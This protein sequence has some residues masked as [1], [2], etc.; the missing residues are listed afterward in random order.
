M[1]DSVRKTCIPMKNSGS[2]LQDMAQETMGS[3]RIYFLAAL[4]PA[5]VP[6]PTSPARSAGRRSGVMERCADFQA[7][8][9]PQRW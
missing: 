6:C 7:L 2:A 1:S 8:L 9:C 5:G 4:K 3:Y